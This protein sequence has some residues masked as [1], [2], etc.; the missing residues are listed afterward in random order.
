MK[1]KKSKSEANCAT[2][3]KCQD[4]LKASIASPVGKPAT[5]PTMCTARRFHAA[6]TCGARVRG[7]STFPPRSM[8]SSFE[9]EPPPPHS[10]SISAA[11]AGP[12]G[13]SNA[14]KVTGPATKCRVVPEGTTVTARALVA[15]CKA[16]AQEA[17]GAVASQ[18][19]NSRL[20]HHSGAGS[21]FRRCDRR[22]TRDRRQQLPSARSRRR[23]ACEDGTAGEGF[24]GVAGGGAARCVWHTDTFGGGEAH[25]LLTRSGA[26]A[27]RQ[28]GRRNFPHGRR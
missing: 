17:R 1:S 6:V 3:R 9:K 27:G 18:A 26:A 5:S 2:Q 4:R 12:A 22:A 11:A 7:S 25:S 21:A 28:R 20:P 14:A 15:A 10:R 19:A 23:R 24:R 8:R 16:L 13:A